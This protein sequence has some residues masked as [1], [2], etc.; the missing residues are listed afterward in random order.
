[1]PPTNTDDGF[2]ARLAVFYAGQFV[3]LGVYMPFLP[4]WLAAKG[5]DAASIGVVLAAPMIVRVIALPA[6]TTFADRR[7][8]LREM[9]RLTAFASP[10]GFI[11]LGLAEGFPLI[12]LAMLIASA[13][14]IST[15]PLADAYALKGLPSRGRAYGSVR[16]WGSAAFIAGSLGAGLLLD[17]LAHEH[18]V[19]VLATVYVVAALAALGLKPTGAQSEQGG[20][21]GAQRPGFRSVAFFGTIAAASLIQASHAVY[22]GFSTLQWS[23][24]GLDGTAIGALWSLAVVAEIVLFALSGRF[25]RWLGP[26]RLLALGA[27]GATLR[28]AGMALDPPA[29]ALPV[30]QCLHALSFGATHLGAVQAVARIARVETTA[31]AQGYLA[32]ALGTVMAAATGLAGVLYGAFGAG[33]YVAMAAIALTGGACVLVAAGVTVGGKTTE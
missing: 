21:L 1:M 32:S 16:L 10:V 2:A 15:F 6:I 27:T 31:T 19:W 3:A 20:N 9:L 5:L 11:I 33:A 23:S 12:L 24:A 30:L 26:M 14:F 8:G 28:W 25:P 18:L 17:R 7:G 22:Y 4:V 13:T 29:V